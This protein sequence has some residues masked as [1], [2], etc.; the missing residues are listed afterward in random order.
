MRWPCRPR[1]CRRVAICSSSS[2]WPKRSGPDDATAAAGSSRRRGAA[3]AVAPRGALGVVIGGGVAPAGGRGRDRTPESVSERILSTSVPEESFWRGGAAGVEGVGGSGVLSDGAA[4]RGAGFGA[5]RPDSVSRRRLSMSLSGAGAFG[6]GAAAAAAGG[7]DAGTTGAAGAGAAGAAG[8]AFGAS[9]SPVRSSSTSEKMSDEVS[10]DIAAATWAVS[11][12]I[13]LAP[14]S[15]ASTASWTEHHE[16]FVG[17]RAQQD[18]ERAHLLRVGLPVRPLVTAHHQDDRWSRGAALFADLADHLG[19]RKAREHAREEDQIE[20]GGPEGLQP[21]LAV[22]GLREGVSVRRQQTSNPLD[23]A[24]LVFDQ[25]NLLRHG[26]EPIV[27][28]NAIKSRRTGISGGAPRP[29]IIRA[30]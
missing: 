27:A 5:I 28:G 22:V 6:A 3:A 13:V 10:G 24:R 9:A 17:K 19:A 1:P 30:R 7:A 20:L 4:G 16:V 23:V 12:R 14:M 15:V 11:I 18:V 26:L 8:A 29:H 21:G 25:K 2:Y